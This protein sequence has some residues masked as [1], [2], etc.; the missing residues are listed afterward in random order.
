MRQSVEAMA[1]LSGT[2]WDANP[3]MPPALAEQKADYLFGG[4]LIFI[5]FLLQLG[6]FFAPTTALLSESATKLAPWAAV[7]LTII[8]FL[9][10]RLAAART[11]KCYEK[12][13]LAW[14]SK[15]FKKGAKT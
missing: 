1:K 8:A 10:L 15:E 14:L 9:L 3:H 6:S 13:I 4:G 2:Y 11:A 7:G 12:Q 5:A